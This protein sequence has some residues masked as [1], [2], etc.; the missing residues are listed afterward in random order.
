MAPLDVPETPFPIYALSSDPLAEDTG[1]TELGG[2]VPDLSGYVVVMREATACDTFVQYRNIAKKNARMFIVY[3]PSPWG[4]PSGVL[5]AKVYNDE[6]AILLLEQ[7]NKGVNVTVTF[8]Q[9]GA[10]DISTRRGGLMALSSSF[11]PTNE[12]RFTPHLA[13]PGANITSTYLTNDGSWAIMSGTSMASPYIAGS[14][15]LLLQA[16]GKG[17][18]T[19]ARAILET[20]SDVVPVSHEKGAMAQTL[21][22]QGAGLVNVLRAITVQT[23]VTPAELSLN[24]TTHW[25][26]MHRVVIKNNAKSSQVYSLTHLPAGTTVTIA[27]GALQMSW[28]PV[29][30]IDAP[31]TL[32]L[33]QTSVTLAPGASATVTAI[34]TPPKN[35]DPKTF[36]IVSGWIQVQGSLGDSLRVSYMGVAGSTSD[37][38]TIATGDYNGRPLPSITYSNFQGEFVQIGPRNYTRVPGVAFFD[39]LLVQASRRVVVDVIDAYTDVKSNVPYATTSTHTKRSVW[40]WWW[41]GLRT[42]TA[43]GSP[44]AVPIIGNA[45]VYNSVPRV[46][47]GNAP[48]FSLALPTKFSNG[49]AVPLGQYRLLLRVL[50]PFGDPSLEKDYDVYVSEQFGFVDS[51]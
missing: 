10:E 1:C 7:F 17:T 14:A 34:F 6:D 44:A 23:D 11:G 33:S 31:V 22:Q 8:T 12:L 20:T 50:H 30:L 43:E 4:A 9:R 3:H 13:A 15:A 47:P 27:P 24:D 46:Q 26:S 37:L 38:Q 49:S 35:V 5:A 21:A 41:P 48:Y 39:F 16:R 18:A 36:P 2:D 40:S 51:L 42:A 29:P 28:D 25:K 32:R 45:A 19:I